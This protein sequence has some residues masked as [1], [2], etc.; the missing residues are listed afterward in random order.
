MIRVYIKA[1]QLFCYGYGAIFSL[2][3]SSLIFKLLLLYYFLFRTT[4]KRLRKN[5][6]HS[7]RSLWPTMSR[8]SAQE[9]TRACSWLSS[10]KQETA[11]KWCGFLSPINAIVYM[12]WVLFCITLHYQAKV[13]TFTNVY[14]YQVSVTANLQSCLCEKRYRLHICRSTLS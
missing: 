8:T 10:S 12:N 9:T 2:I 14:T 5:I 11:G 7:M 13:C 3:V 1:V 6:R 4:W